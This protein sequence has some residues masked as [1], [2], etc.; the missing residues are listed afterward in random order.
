M[1]HNNKK[2]GFALTEVLMAI[3][4]II[5]IGIV[6]YPLYTQ[7]RQDAAVNQVYNDIA[8]VRTTVDTNRDTILSGQ[9][10]AQG[11]GGFDVLTWMYGQ[12]ILPDGIVQD[13]LNGPSQYMQVVAED[14]QLLISFSPQNGSSSSIPQLCIDIS[15]EIY[16]EF[17]IYYQVNGQAITSNGVFSPT[18]KFDMNTLI[19]NCE[20]SAQPQ[21]G[22]S[23]YL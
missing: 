7:S 3:A 4:V 20:S 13:P 15:K 9:N 23:G 21:W 16:S 19:T 2:K 5:V 14:N 22:G 12:H 11:S 6:A 8:L 10:S 1:K 18:E 17:N